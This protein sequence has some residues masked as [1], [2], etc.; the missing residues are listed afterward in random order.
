MLRAIEIREEEYIAFLQDSL[1]NC[2]YIKSVTFA[3]TATPGPLSENALELLHHYHMLLS[4]KDNPDFHAYCYAIGGPY[5]IWVES[6]EAI[7]TDG[8]TFLETGVHFQDIWRMG[9]EY[10]QNGG[11]DTEETQ[12]IRSLMKPHWLA[13]MSSIVPTST[14]TMAQLRLKICADFRDIL[15][16]LEGT[17][18]TS[19][20]KL[21]FL[22]EEGFSRGELQA[23]SADC[24][25]NL[26]Q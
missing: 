8:H 6:G 17:D 12:Y 1:E 26:S 13:E 9:W 5:Y 2:R 7:N 23:L 10:C 20:Q 4:F 21:A 11:R 25:V 3:P 22:L 18:L 14:P 19:D 24:P 16:T 15:V